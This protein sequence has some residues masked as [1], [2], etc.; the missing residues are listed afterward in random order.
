MKI[1]FRNGF[2]MNNKELSKK[3]IE[4]LYDIHSD[5]VNSYNHHNDKGVIDKLESYIECR[6]EQE[7]FAKAI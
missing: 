3:T 6:L 1:T 7:E 2:T 4:E 5:L